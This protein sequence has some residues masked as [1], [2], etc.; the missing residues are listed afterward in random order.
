MC[1][2]GFQTQDLEL[3]KMF[4][5]LFLKPSEKQF[6]EQLLLPHVAC[7]MFNGETPEAVADAGLR[8]VSR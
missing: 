8:N 5:K 2:P 1:S 3:G 6:L 7:N 4:S